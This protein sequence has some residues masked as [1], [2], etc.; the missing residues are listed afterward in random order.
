MDKNKTKLVRKY[1][2]FVIGLLTATLYTLLSNSSAYAD[3]ISE[4]DNVANT[5]KSLLTGPVSV[6]FGG[7]L[8]LVATYHLIQKNWAAMI[9]WS[10]AAIFIL[11]LKSFMSLFGGN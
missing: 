5:F 3:I 11:G 7:L 4:G 9:S 6:V 1:G 10:L 2:L 8:G